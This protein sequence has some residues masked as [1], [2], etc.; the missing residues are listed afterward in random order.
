MSMKWPNLQ[1][2]C[3]K[4]GAFPFKYLGV[5]LYHD[6]LKREDIQPIVDKTINRIPGLKGKLL[7]Y[8]ARLILLSKHSNI[9]NVSY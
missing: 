5:P 7:S 4:I 1:K 2:K 6:K 8:S 3:C 9:F